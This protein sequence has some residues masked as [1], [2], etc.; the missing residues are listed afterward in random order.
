MRCSRL[1]NGLLVGVA[2]P[3]ASPVLLGLLMEDGVEQLVQAPGALD[4][5]VGQPGLVHDAHRGPIG[6]GLGDGVGIDER[7]EVAHGAP[8]E[9][10]VDEECP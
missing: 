4:G 5:E 2:A 7:A 1:R 8:A 6:H 3:D 9:P 10:L